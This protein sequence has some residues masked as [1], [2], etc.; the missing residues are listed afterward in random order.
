MVRRCISKVSKKRL[1]AQRVHKT[2]HCAEHRAIIALRRSFGKTGEPD[3]IDY[4]SRRLRGF[5]HLSPASNPHS[6]TTVW[7]KRP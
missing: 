2:T 4:G 3:G 1:Q 6:D 7:R 5:D